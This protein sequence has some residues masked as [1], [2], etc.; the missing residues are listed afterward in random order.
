MHPFPALLPVSKGILEVVFSEG[1]Q[2]R[3]RSASTA[4]IASK[5]RHLSFIFNYEKMGKQGR[6][7]TTVMVFLIKISLVKREVWERFVVVMQ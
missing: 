1:V 6:W 5:W 4:L 7:R 3:L 2:R